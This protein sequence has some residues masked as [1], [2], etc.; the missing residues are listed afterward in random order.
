MSKNIFYKNIGNGNNW[1]KI[2]PI[3]TQMNRSAIGAKV[4]VTADINGV[5]K[6]QMREISAQ[7]GYCGQNSL[8]AHFGLADATVAK[9]VRVQFACGAIMTL[10]NI[11]SNQL[12]EVTEGATPTKETFSNEKLT[13]KITPNP[14]SGQC[15]VTINSDEYM[16]NAV[17]N[18][19]DTSG[20]I[21]WE[22]KLENIPFGYFE[23]NIDSK[24]IGLKPG[25]Y[26]LEIKGNG[27]IKSE[28]LIVY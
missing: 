25:S 5:E 21:V 11:F 17:L 20:R 3:G 27:L 28:L 12:I 10:A 9:E 6:T 23:K 15:I 16:K 19:I 4:Y 13:V 8:Y 7:S 18:L 14:V 1:I 26:I 2:K 22:S 24:K